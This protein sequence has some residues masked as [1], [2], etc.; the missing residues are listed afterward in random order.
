MIDEKLKYISATDQEIELNNKAPY[1]LLTID[2]AGQAGIDTQTQ[3]AAYQDGETYVD[4]LLDYRNIN[5]DIIIKAEDEQELFNK[6]KE[7]QKIFNPKNGPGKLIYTRAGEEK[8]VRAI[9]DDGP[10]FPS[11]E[12]NRGITFQR[13]SIT[14]LCPSPFWEDIKE[15][16]EPLGFIEGGL[17]FPLM[18]N[19]DVQEHTLFGRRGFT[20][21]LEN[22]GDV[23]APVEIV[24]SGPAENTKIINKTTG[25]FI[26]INQT[27]G[28]NEKLHI[29]TAFGNKRAEIEDE[30]GEMTNAF[31]Y[32]DLESTFW[33]LKVGV[34]DVDFES[35]ISKEKASAEISFRNRYVGI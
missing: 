26:K 10:D 24:F 21:L 18:L 25:E 1:I 17:T 35:D 31:H 15:T 2:G 3:K 14:L 20:A 28:E 27:I 11:G 8:Q 6:R 22:K 12:N 29:N 23:P 7:L 30:N 9:V 5:I 16:G 33:E 13:S 19:P 4:S 32:L 34:N